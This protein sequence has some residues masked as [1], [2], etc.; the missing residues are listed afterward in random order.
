MLFLKWC[1]T[2]VIFLRLATHCLSLLQV[3]ILKYSLKLHILEYML[4]Y[5]LESLS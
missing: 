3:Y 4:K 2:R 1:Q 5:I